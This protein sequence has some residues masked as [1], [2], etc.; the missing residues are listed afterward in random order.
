T[1]RSTRSGRA[2]IIT[3][4]SYKRQ[5]ETSSALKEKTTNNVTRIMLSFMHKEVHSSDE[6]EDEGQDA[7]CIYCSRLFSRD[8]KGEK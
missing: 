3:G 2:A 6:Y 1:T 5:L 8:K 4:S 7:E